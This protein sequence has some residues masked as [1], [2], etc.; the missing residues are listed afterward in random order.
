MSDSVVEARERAAKLLSIGSAQ[1][2]ANVLRGALDLQ[3]D[4][5]LFHQLG[6]AQE[7]LVANEAALSSFEAALQI[8]PK[9]GDSLFEKGR[10]LF[11]LQR[12]PEAIHAFRAF[13]LIE[14][15][16]APGYVSLAHALARE[17]RPVEAA[18]A[19]K[20]AVEL[21]PA[22]AEANLLLGYQYQEFG[23]FSQALACFER[24]ISVRPSWGASYLGRATSKAIVQDDPFV[25]DL[26][27][28]L[29]EREI[30]DLDR[31]DLHYAMGKV[32]NDLENYEAAILEYE[33]G[34]ALA[35]KTMNST[36]R[37]FD[38]EGYRL[39][40]D[41]MVQFFTA[42]LFESQRELGLE[43]LTPI[44][45]VGM[46]R[47]GSTLLEQMLSCHPD[48]GA[49]GELLFWRGKGGLLYQKLQQQQATVA[50]VQELGTEYLELLNRLGGGKSRITDKMPNNYLYLGAF[51][52]AFPRAKIIVTERHPVD[53]CL[54]LYMTPSRN[55]GPLV[56]SLET[57][58]Q[59]Y[60]GYSR[61][62]QHWRETLPPECFRVIW[63]EDV[64]GDP[65]PQMRELLSWLDLGWSEEVLHPERNARIVSTPSAWQ[66]RQPLYRTSVERWK[67]YEPWLGPLRR[68][69]PK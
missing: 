43:D 60:E 52:V 67:R 7:M 1:L 54:S 34:H 13:L 8:D 62:I 61:M 6:L 40:V 65:E 10:V 29:R 30:E 66:V 25:V 58:T 17:I 19:L 39:H 38:R 22:H 45:I 4:A 21:D 5:E 32:A 63:Y 48:V 15:R 12:I 41:R 42:A 64:I 56:H 28:R 36:Q 69:L 49:A 59:V 47:S 9:R 68:L 23:D 26:E 24:A 33:R 27:K 31:R 11:A 37:P 55:P 46:P 14:P 2:A 50:L 35:A 18:E 51:H 16:S 57:L 20:R 3:P 44:L 53:N